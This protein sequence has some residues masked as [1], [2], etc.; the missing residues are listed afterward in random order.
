MTPRRQKRALRR[1]RVKYT[2]RGSAEQHLGYTVNISTTGMFVATNRPLPV[3]TRVRIQIGPENRDFI[4]EAEVARVLRSQQILQRVLPSGMG[5]R[6]LTVAE[7]VAELAPETASQLP[8]KPSP[9]P[10]SPRPEAEEGVYQVVFNDR[11]QLLAALESDI[12]TGW[13]FVPTLEPAAVDEV[14]EIDLVVS[15]HESE[16]LRLKTK[17]VECFEPI[18][19]DDQPNLLAGMGVQVSS[20]EGAMQ[21]ILGLLARIPS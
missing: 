17:V 10:R 14:V 13:L 2:E 4:L 5:L 15:G 21:K 7:L 16:T 1:F 12:K 3:G 18:A 19:G 11:Q 6:F 20:F 8:P 9:A